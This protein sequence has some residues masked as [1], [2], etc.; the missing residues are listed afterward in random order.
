MG[1]QKG[2]NNVKKVAS[3]QCFQKCTHSVTILVRSLYD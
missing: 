2:W 3:E 1:M